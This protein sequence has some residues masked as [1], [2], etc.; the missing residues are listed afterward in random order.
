[1]YLFIISFLHFSFL[2]LW[3]II[4]STTFSNVHI[5]SCLVIKV[6]LSSCW[7]CPASQCNPTMKRIGHS[8]S[9]IGLMLF[10]FLYL[11][12]QFV[13]LSQCHRPAQITYNRIY[14]A[15][16]CIF[17]ALNHTLNMIVSCERN[18][19]VIFGQPKKGG[20]KFHQKAKWQWLDYL[21]IFTAYLNV[22]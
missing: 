12:Y 17:K 14:C 4:F 13:C 10:L 6:M 11:L 7:C 21:L 22:V 20:P 8:F 18:M 5:S 9:S 19:V 15:V 1:M 2:L 16:V 3:T